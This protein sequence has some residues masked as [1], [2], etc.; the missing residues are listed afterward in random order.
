MGSTWDA[1]SSYLLSTGFSHLFLILNS[2][3]V[4]ID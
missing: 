3:Q 4:S 2:S 1:G